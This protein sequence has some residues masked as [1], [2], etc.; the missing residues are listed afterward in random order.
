M[1]RIPCLLLIAALLLV[2]G[3]TS[4]FEVTPL[5]EGQ[6]AVELTV[7]GETPEEALKLARIE[8]VRGSVGRVFLGNYLLRADDLLNKYLGNYGDQFVSAVEIVDEQFV[9]GRNRI[10]ARVYVD[11]A[12]LQEDLEQKKFLYQPA[13]KPKFTTFM[14]E[15]LDGRITTGGDA[16]GALSDALNRRGMRR[17]QGELPRPPSTTDVANDEFLLETAII[18]SQ[19]AGIEVIVSGE[20]RTELAQ[21]QRL[22]FDDYWFYD[23]EMTARIVRVDTGEL[24]FEASGYGSAS[25]KDQGEAAQVAIERAADKVAE[26]LTEDF[27]A[28]WPIVVQ[29]E[30]DYELLFTGVDDEL[31]RIIIQSIERL[32]RDTKVYVRKGFDRSTMLAVV[33]PGPKQDLL[34]NLRSTPYPTLSIVNPEAQ[35]TFEVQ[36]SD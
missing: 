29:G 31:V 28:F 5:D 4:A 11:F 17:Y 3:R 12:G 33:Y 1:R 30:A 16:R 34:E 10:Q 24:L 8:A 21:K 32:G 22:Y 36:V 19:R 25:A 2:A 35:S 27:E 7:E 23:S 18:S 14:T 6:L 9:A 15:R 13:Y 26:Q 20:S